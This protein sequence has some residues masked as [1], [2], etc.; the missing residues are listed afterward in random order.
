MS[1]QNVEA[2]KRALEASN[3]SDHDALL[4]EFDP[5][6]EW[7]GVMGVMFGGEATVFKGHAGVLEYLRDIDEGFTVRDIEWSEF[8][9]LGERVVVLG[10]ARGRG[11][12]SEIEIDSQYGAVAE[13]RRGKIIR[14]RDFFNHREALKAAGLEE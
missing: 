9:D 8:R 13:F 7:H 10:H 14:Y 3:R 6:V 1:Q 5:D 12:E 11:R 2:F 4:A